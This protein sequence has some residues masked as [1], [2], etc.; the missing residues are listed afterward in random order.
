MI[1]W[2][3]VNQGKELS[4][5]LC[6]SYYSQSLLFFIFLDN[7]SLQLQIQLYYIIIILL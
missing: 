5:H 6:M 3:S 7:S 2:L 4:F 1:W